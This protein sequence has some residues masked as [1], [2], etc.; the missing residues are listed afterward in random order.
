MWKKAF[1]QLCKQ[2]R[3]E[4]L[5]DQVNRRH[6][7]SQRCHQDFAILR[8]DVPPLQ[9]SAIPHNAATRVVATHSVATKP[10]RIFAICGTMSRHHSAVTYSLNAAD[11]CSG[12]TSC[13]N[14][15]TRIFAVCGTVSRHYDSSPTISDQSSSS[16]AS[17]RDG[18]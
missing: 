12:D 4:S 16:S 17:S 6:I 1:A 5:P 10:T 9:R 7:V 15:A 13:R 11:R 2:Q 3:K 14:D 8:D 18:W